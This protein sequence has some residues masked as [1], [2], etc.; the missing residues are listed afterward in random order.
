MEPERYCVY[1]HDEAPLIGAGHRL[2]IAKVGYKWVH[3]RTPN[4]LRGT[5]IKRQ[6]WDK[7]RKE[8]YEK[9]ALSEPNPQGF[10]HSE[11][12]NTNCV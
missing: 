12:P 10:A 11:I 8:R 1:F 5:K 6:T 7:L 4:A 9:K 2:V 3:V